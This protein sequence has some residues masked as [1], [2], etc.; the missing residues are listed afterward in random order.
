MSDRIEKEKEFHNTRFAEDT[1]KHL[2]KYYS[3]ISNASKL[4]EELISANVSGKKI[5]EYGCGEGSLSF[6]LAQKGAEVYGIDISDVAI[7]KA[8]EISVAQ[9]LDDS[10][11]FYVMNAE[12][13]SF[14][15]NF[16]DTICGSAILHH[17]DLDKALSALKKVI[18]KDGKAIFFEPLGHN[19]FIN[20]YRTLTGNLR[21][22]DEHPLKIK[23]L[24]LFEKYFTNIDIHYFHLTTL[25]AVPFRR[26][27]FFAQL[28][29]FFNKVD[30]FL[31]R[32]SFFKK[33]A[34]IVV[35]KLTQ[36]LK[37]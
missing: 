5:L 17:L 33:N 35:I 29:S 30:N 3:I 7:E 25:M 10:I 37:S 28:L 11:K 9:K 31:F 21:T 8:Q 19:I 26:F 6:D 15:G 36:P 22:E 1:R 27:G 16:F 14:E 4:Y 20:L 23:D 18:K 13:L 32:F 2:S 12:E 34:W 24:K